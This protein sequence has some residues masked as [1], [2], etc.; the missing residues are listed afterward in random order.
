MDS[1]EED[2][3]FVGTPIEREEEN[4]SRKKKALAQA[5][6]QL[7]TLVPWKQEVR[8]EE[9][10][11]RFH[12]AFTGGYSAG[13]YNTVGSKE[14][15]TPQSFTSSRKNRADFK[16]QSIL[17]FLDDD[18]KVEMEGNLLGTSAQFDTFG[19]TAAEYAR[20]EAE[21]EQKQRPAPIPGPVPDEIVLHAVDSIGVKL[22]CTMGWRRGCSIKAHTRTLQDARM[23]GQK[24]FLSLSSHDAVVRDDS[25]EIEKNNSD[26]FTE[27][28]VNEIYMSSDS[29]SDQMHLRQP[30]LDMYG[31]GYDP[32]RHAPEF[33]EKKNAGLTSGKG[34]GNTEL[35]SVKDDLLSSRSG[36]L[37]PGFGIGALEELDVE[38]EDVYSSG[39]NFE[40]TYAHEEVEEPSGLAIENKEK[41]IQK[42]QSRFPRFRTASIP[43]HQTERFSPPAIPEDFV[44]HHKFLAALEVNTKVSCSPPPE[45]PAP[46]DNNCK[47]IIEGVASLVARCGILFEDLSREKN[48]SNPLFSF[49]SGGIGSGYYARRLWEEQQR[50]LGQPK[51]ISDVRSSSRKQKLTAD[52]RGRVLGEKPLERSCKESS[53]VGTSSDKSQ[54]NLSDT[55]TTPESLN[56][57]FE[58][59]KPFKDDPAKQER[60]EQFIRAKYQGGLRSTNSS[61]ASNMSEASRARERLDFE[62]AAEIIEKSKRADKGKVSAQLMDFSKSSR[63]QFTSAGV[64]DKSSQVEDLASIKL[65]PKREEFQWRPASLLCKRFDVM[66]PFMGKPPPAPRIR[67]K[68]ESFLFT[69]DSAKSTKEEDVEVNTLQFNSN[70]ISM[71]SNNAENDVAVEAENVE[72]PVD[73]YKASAIF[74]DDS[75]GEEETSNFNEADETQNKIEAA[76]AT[77]SRLAAGDFLESLGKELGLEV[78]PPDLPLVIG[79]NSSSQRTQVLEMATDTTPAA[80][81]SISN[82]KE[83]GNPEPSNTLKELDGRSTSSSV[84]HYY[85]SDRSSSKDERS[86]KKSRRHPKHCPSTR[87]H[88]T[89]VA[90]DRKARSSSGRHRYDSDRSSSDDD[91]RKKHSRLHQRR[92]HSSSSKRSR[93]DSPPRPVPD[94]EKGE[95]YEERLTL[96]FLHNR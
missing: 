28:P 5:S 62:A 8:D 37:A 43:D 40:E 56:Q 16:Q 12:G 91:W 46:E 3:V 13:Y 17:N 88:N 30:K 32:Y 9:G 49:L 45:V 50:R 87:S 51:L 89:E 48:Q 72:R 35:F 64:E 93:E 77:F 7:R 92:N 94:P 34:V 42:E 53:L 70:E 18:E 11:R 6:G 29:K 20:K 10:R 63:L 78:P 68:M 58:T 57:L 44:P 61:G 83:E 1:D 24:T 60:F 69:P 59:A 41:P 66:D 73:L 71:E 38:D 25:S 85:D 4:T 84:R 65:Y 82:A 96:T 80:A 36:R 54:F 19:F 31:L 79:P 21:N 27:G 90:A 15:W 22:L 67:S 76:T 95:A 14:G 47:L 86:K 23:E 75:D 26:A 33:R 74:S 55:F 81:I 52:D 39:Y 2:F